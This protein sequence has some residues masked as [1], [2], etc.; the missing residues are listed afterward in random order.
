MTNQFDTSGPEEW[1][2]SEVHGLIFVS[3]YLGLDAGEASDREMAT[4]ADKRPR[5]GAV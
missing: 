3:Y 5:K 1:H 4:G 2:D